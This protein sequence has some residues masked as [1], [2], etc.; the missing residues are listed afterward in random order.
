MPEI[1]IS[2]SDNNNNHLEREIRKFKRL[3]DK[4]GL[5]AAARNNAYHEKPTAIRK[6]QH[7]AAVKR[8]EK[9]LRKEKEMLESMM[10]SRLHRKSRRN[11]VLPE[12]LS[13]TDTELE[14]KAD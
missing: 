13:N 3:V 7:A 8:W 5:A 6:R 10:R 9:K 14:N 2:S 1:H 4:A 11:P 12:D